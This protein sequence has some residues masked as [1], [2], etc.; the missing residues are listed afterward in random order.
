MPFTD[1]N[2]VFLPRVRVASPTFA[3]STFEIED[4]V[5]WS[6]QF[7]INPN[8]VSIT[9]NYVEPTTYNRSFPAISGGDTTS[10]NSYPLNTDSEPVKGTF[11]ITATVVVTGAVDPNTYTRTINVEICPFAVEAAYSWAVNCLSTPIVKATETT[12]Y[13]TGSTITSYSK[14]LTPPPVSGLTAYT[15]T[16]VS[17]DSG[18]DNGYKGVYSLSS[19]TVATHSFE[20]HQ[21]VYTVTGSS[22]RNVVCESVCEIKC[23]LD[24][25]YDKAFASCSPNRTS[26]EWKAFIDASAMLRLMEV[27]LNDC[28]DESRYQI[29]LDRI[30]K[31]LSATNCDDCS[32]SSSNPWIVPVFSGSITSVTSSSLLVNVSGT[33]VTIDLTAAHMA[34]LN[35]VLNYS[36][37]SDTLDIALGAQTVGNPNTQPVDLEVKDSVRARAGVEITFSVTIIAGVASFSNYSA[38]DEKGDQYTDPSLGI[39]ADTHPNSPNSGTEPAVVVVEDFVLTAG[40]NLHWKATVDVINR[41]YDGVIST[42]YDASF[43]F[44]E[45]VPP[46]L[47]AHVLKTDWGT[48]KIYIGFEL[49]NVTNAWQTIQWATIEQVMPVFWLS[50]KISQ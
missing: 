31:I 7:G 32:S 12:A 46:L 40:P 1:N 35:N 30:K 5:E 3:N 39:S 10:T 11:K 36:F 29:Y 25:A 14:T 8:D 41:T 2:I 42:W 6:A 22:T 9:Y 27:A 13:P 20:G 47:R 18:T 16:V 45:S 24:K 37:T 23:L 48:G 34:V 26:P 44:A 43:G 49:S 17:V 4:T 21:I 28:D 38:V 50:V 33:T 19:T 15:S